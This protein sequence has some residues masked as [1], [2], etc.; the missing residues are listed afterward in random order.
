MKSGLAIL[1]LAVNT[2]SPSAPAFHIEETTID[3]I[4]S[5]ILKGQLT[6]I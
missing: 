2:I 4:Q 1:L 6:S 5:A 3:G